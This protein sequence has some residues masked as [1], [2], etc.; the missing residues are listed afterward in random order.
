MFKTR[1]PL[2]VIG[3]M[4]VTAVATAGS[5]ERRGTKRPHPQLAHM[6]FFKLKI[7]RSAMRQA[8]RVVQTLSLGPSGHHLFWSRLARRRPERKFN[9]RDFDVS[10]HLV[11][12]NKE[13]QD[14]YQ[15]SERHVK[16]IQENLESLEKVRV[17]DSSLSPVPE[18]EKTK[19]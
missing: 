16:F 6:V 19:D 17:F 4:A 10:L 5:L 3:L 18:A 15:E 11:F 1:N 12:K 9:D 14:T 13:A 2:I 8:D 7:I